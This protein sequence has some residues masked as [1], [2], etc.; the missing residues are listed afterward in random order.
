MPAGA[1]GR[2]QDRHLFRAK[3]YEFRGL[4]SSHPVIS[5]RGL[6]IT[7]TGSFVAIAPSPEFGA[8]GGLPGFYLV[9]R[10]DVRKEAVILST[11]AVLIQSHG[12]CL[13]QDP[14]QP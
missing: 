14:E 12:L 6:G 9:P 7:V 13:A 10:A 1:A 3:A 2:F 4:K 11:T 5:S 8:A